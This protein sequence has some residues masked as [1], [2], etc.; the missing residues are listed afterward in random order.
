MNR[1]A[2]ALL[3]ALASCAADPAG[4][5][6]AEPTPAPARAKGVDGPGD[7]ERRA[8]F[9]AGKSGAETATLVATNNP[10]HLDAVAAFFADPQKPYPERLAALVAL[11]ALRGQDPGEYARVYPA[12]KTKLWE[13]AAHGDGLAMSRE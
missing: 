2:A 8:K 9:L 11:R 6:P 4:L 1:A 13:E 7:A 12:V 10:A 5:P 3:L